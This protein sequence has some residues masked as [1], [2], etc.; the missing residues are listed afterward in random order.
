MSTTRFATPGDDVY[1]LLDDPV[2]AEIADGVGRTPAQ[3]VLRW[4]VQHGYVVFPKSTT[5]ARIKENFELFDF[6]LD[7]SAMERIDDLDE[8]E[9]GR[10]G[11]HPDRFAYV[12]S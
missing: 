9:P 12:P 4:H 5:P 2:I 6:E 8:G 11:P 1:C 10:I 3:V 7:A